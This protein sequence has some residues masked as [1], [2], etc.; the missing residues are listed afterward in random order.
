[1]KKEKIS[2]AE[3]HRQRVFRIVDFM[4]QL[5]GKNVGERTK[6]WANLEHQLALRKQQKEIGRFQKVIGHGH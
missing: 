1:M 6:I 2:H 5:I 3:Q 4:M